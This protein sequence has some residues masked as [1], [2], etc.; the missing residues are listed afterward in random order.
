MWKSL[1]FLLSGHERGRTLLYV[2][3]I[4]RDDMTMTSFAPAAAASICWSALR[5]YNSTQ[6]FNNSMLMFV[7]SSSSSSWVLRT[8]RIQY[9]RKEKFSYS[10]AHALLRSFYVLRRTCAK[11]RRFMKFNWQHL[12]EFS[13]VKGISNTFRWNGTESSYVF[14]TTL[15]ER[16]IRRSW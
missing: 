11:N 6:S 3:A 12:T 5:M 1:C 16:S 2:R 9:S 13:Y 15:E 10:Y 8:F 7:R 4:A 14:L